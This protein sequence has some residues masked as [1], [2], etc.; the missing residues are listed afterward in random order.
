MNNYNKG[1]I[2][3]DC[4]LLD[5]NKNTGISRYTEFLIDYYINRFGEDK[6]ILI[7]NDEL[8]FCGA[9]FI[10][11]K[12][13]PYTILDFLLFPFFVKS[14]KVSII[15]FPFYS[16]LWIKPCNLI[17]ILTVHDLMFLRVKNFFSNYYLLN[18]IGRFYYYFIVYLSIKTSDNIISVSNS[19]S[20]D[21]LSIFNTKS[22]IIP[23]N[24]ELLCIPDESIL[25]NNK[26]YKGQFFFYSGNSRPH[27]NIKFLRRIFEDNPILP[28]LVLCGPGHE[29]E[30]TRVKV[31]GVVSDS[32]L[33]ALYKNCIAFVFPSV[34]EGFGLPV[35]E[36]LR[37]GS[38][39][40]LS[41]IPAFIEFASSPALHYFDP[42]S[43]EQC[44]NA[45]QNSATNPSVSPATFFHKYSTQ[46]IYEKLDNL[47][48]HNDILI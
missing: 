34:Y 2:A 31:L 27:K 8:K 21:I 39:V 1:L 48:L 43:S 44:I 42:L 23:E 20:V 33:L 15:H 47:F 26:L 24:S 10:T 30:T 45:L 35:I 18:L 28:I 5:K 6:V 7:A 4:R 17:S 9:K 32:E 11:T 16:G 14:L 46:N 19:T 13:K 3:L 38:Q 40:V 22:I 29:Q 12:L 25:N 41:R 37:A 36:G